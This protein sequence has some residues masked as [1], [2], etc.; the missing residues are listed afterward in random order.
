MQTK[1]IHSASDNINLLNY[2]NKLQFSPQEPGEL[3]FR[4]GEIITVTDSSDE[5][6][7]QGTI[8]NRK[9]QFPATYVAPYNPAEQK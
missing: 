6:W 3:E 2:L 9:G 8:Q 4:R 5:N 7:W 1:Q